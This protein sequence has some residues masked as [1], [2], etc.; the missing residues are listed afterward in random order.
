[1]AF[2]TLWG[3]LGP[4][5]G[6]LRPHSRAAQV[7][8]TLTRLT[9]LM[10]NEGRHNFPVPLSSLDCSEHDFVQRGVTLSE[11]LAQLP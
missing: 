1:M 9:F 11:T 2:T 3:P 6:R 10:K 4:V 8:S 5:R 7:I